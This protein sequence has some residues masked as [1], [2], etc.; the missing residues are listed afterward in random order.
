LPLRITQRIDFS[1][2]TLI[3]YFFS[4]IIIFGSCLNLAANNS[5]VNDSWTIGEWLI[6]YQGGFVRRG[7]LGEV[8]FLISDYFSI[9]PI[10]I[11]W[12]ICLSS[13]LFLIKLSFG[14]VKNL[15]STSFLLSPAIFLSPIIGNFLVR[16]D[17]LLLLLFVCNLRI[18]KANKSN[19][20]F[21]NLINIF[22]TLIHEGFFIYALPIQFFLKL[23]KNIFSSNKNLFKNILL[24]LPSI[25]VFLLC[26]I[27]KGSDYQASLINNSWID[28]SFLFPFDDFINGNPSGAIDAIGWGFNDVVNLLSLSLR[29]FKGF[30]WVPIAWG[31]TILIIGSI[32]LGDNKSKDAKLKLFILSFQF[33]PLILLCLLGWDYG[34]WIFIWITSSI[35]IYSNFSNEIKNLE[36]Y[37]RFSHKFNFLKNNKFSIELNRKSKILLLFT[38]YPH[39][40]W[41]LFYVPTLLVVPLYSFLKSEFLRNK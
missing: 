6:N 41:S 32:F 22:A 14:M 17:I 13:Y 29:D 11:I 5:Y 4:L 9:T 18:I 2:N 3:T 28:K 23:N 15:V 26:F 12:I 36:L 21:I 20:F 31:L 24:F 8:I 10:Y 35:F 40:C 16:K 7:L 33:F 34:R 39:C 38:S 30:L 25:I 1:P 19:I 27:F 37:K